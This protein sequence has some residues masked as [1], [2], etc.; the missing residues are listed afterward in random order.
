MTTLKSKTQRSAIEPLNPLRAIALGFETV[1]EYLHLLIVP[2]LLDL[3]FWLGPQLRLGQFL[4]NF[5]AEMYRLGPMSDT[6]ALQTAV[7]PLFTRYNLLFHLTPIFLG[8]PSL[9][10]TKAPLITP[11]GE[12]LVFEVSNAGQTLLVQLLCSFFG[13]LLGSLYFTQVSQQIDQKFAKITF[14][15]QT[16]SSSH[17]IKI[18]LNLLLLGVVGLVAVFVLGVPILLVLGLLSSIAPSVAT[19]VTVLLFSLLMWGG[20][21]LLFTIPAVV[22]QQFWFFPAL[23]ASLRTV[24]Q[25]YLHVVWLFVLYLALQFLSQLAWGLPQDQSWL[26]ILSIIGHAFVSTALTCAIFIFYQNHIR[27]VSQSAD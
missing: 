2:I 17:F 24:R 23:L 13:I 5:L 3:L 15:N 27:W 20:M 9:M 26:L 10:V 18:W 12:R 8:V 16:T 19:L 21:F 1:A 22:Q 11:F 25:R 6:A 4:Q 14:S 7:E